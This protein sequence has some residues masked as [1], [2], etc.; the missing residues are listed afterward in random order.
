MVVD[1]DGA[2]DLIRELAQRFE[3]LRIAEIH[4]ELRVERF[5][6]PV[7]PRACLLAAGDFDAQGGE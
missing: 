4:F 2:M 5:L 3:P 7:F 1:P 6:H